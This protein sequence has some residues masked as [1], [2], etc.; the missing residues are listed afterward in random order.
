MGKDPGDVILVGASGC[1]TFHST[2]WTT[3]LCKSIGQELALAAGDNM[4]LVTGGMFGA[5]C[6]TREPCDLRC[7]GEIALPVLWV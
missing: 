3:K 1:G 5:A 7:S 6:G 4:A 2:E